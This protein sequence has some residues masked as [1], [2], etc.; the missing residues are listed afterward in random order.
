LRDLTAAARFRVVDSKVIRVETGGLLISVGNG[1][2]EIVAEIEGKAIKLAVTVAGADQEQP[3][4]FTNEIVPLFAK[5]GCNAGA[6]HGKASG[7]NGFKLSLLG[8]EPASDYVALTREA[9]GRRIFPAAPASSL[10]LL[11]STGAV[12]HSGGK[13]LDPDSRDYQ[14]ILRWL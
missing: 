3:V 14:A 6:C 4:N 7:Q 12:A 10:L 13:R 5:L 1:T 9:R 8:S 11:K 2:S